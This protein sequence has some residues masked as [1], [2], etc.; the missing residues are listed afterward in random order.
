MRKLVRDG[1]FTGLARAQQ[2]HSRVLTQVFAEAGKRAAIQHS[3]ILS[4]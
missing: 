3:C 1:G 4:I 2:G